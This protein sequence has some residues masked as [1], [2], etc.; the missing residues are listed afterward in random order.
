MSKRIMHLAGLDGLDSDTVLSVAA[1][2]NYTGETEAR[3]SQARIGSRLSIRTADGQKATLEK[4][5]S[6]RLKRLAK[7]QARVGRILIRQVAGPWNQE[8]QRN[9]SSTFTDYLTPAAQAARAA[10]LV[11]T[12]KAEWR[13]MTGEERRACFDDHAQAA[14]DSLPVAAQVAG[15]EAGQNPL[16]VTEYLIH[17]ERTLGGSLEKGFDKLVNI[18]GDPG[19]ALSSLERLQA[20]VLKLKHS[21]YKQCPELRKDITISSFPVTEGPQDI[22]G[23]AGERER[24]V[25]TVG[26]EPPPLPDI[27]SP[28]PPDILSPTPVSKSSHFKGL[29]PVNPE[30]YQFWADRYLQRFKAVLIS[31]GLTPEG[32][33]T[34][35]KGQDCSSPGKHPWGGS[36]NVIRSGEELLKALKKVD[37]PNLGLPTGKETGITVLDFDGEEGKA[38]FEEWQAEGLILPDMLTASTGGGGVHVVIEHIPGLSAKVRTL[39]G[40]DIRN[41]GTQIVTAPS[42][43]RSGNLYTWQNWP[44]QILPAPAA[45]VDKLKTPAIL[46]QL[47]RPFGQSRS[48][49]AP[50]A[51][52]VYP[53]GE[54]NQAV[55]R[56]ACGIAGGGH[57]FDRIRTAALAFNDQHCA[58]PLPANEVEIIARS[59]ARYPANPEAKGGRI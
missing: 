33:C 17:F 56:Y 22:E 15:P 25:N 10:F 1:C 54:R 7:G 31:Y 44:G 53:Q 51:G 45:L 57:S 49:P 9:E 52:G 2:L 21:L 4:A 26:H 36:K 37:N 27:M 8:T 23:G 43:H 50:A 42:L 16:S 47:S 24:M 46:P 29:R 38:L 32:A 14:L 40:L 58:P 19:A 39:P 55:F 5:A 34:C 59:A 20:E 28:T 12:Q 11:D 30:V 35:P 13:K 18:Y 41:E 48:F 3:I 6:R